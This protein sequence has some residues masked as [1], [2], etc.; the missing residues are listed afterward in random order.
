MS[1]YISIRE[2][3]E[4]L[5]IMGEN[6]ANMPSESQPIVDEHLLYENFI[7]DCIENLDNKSQKG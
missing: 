3:D 6:Y 1:S 5:S 4:I 2:C 7:Q